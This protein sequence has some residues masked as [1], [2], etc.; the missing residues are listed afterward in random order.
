MIVTYLVVLC[1]IGLCHL[2]YISLL[3][4]FL[5]L[6][7]ERQEHKEQDEHA[8][9]EPSIWYTYFST[10][11]TFLVQEK[12][13]FNFQEEKNKGILHKFLEAHIKSIRRI[14][15]VLTTYMLF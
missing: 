15:T 3:K 10:C 12:C 5:K 6:E 8:L 2:G 1:G 14:I 11:V 9:L 4:Y 7:N 13:C